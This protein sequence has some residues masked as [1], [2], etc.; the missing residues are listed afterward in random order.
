MHITID[1]LIEKAD[2]ARALAMEKK[3]AAAAISAIKELGVLLGYRAREEDG[4][5]V[6]NMSDDELADIAR[7]GG[8]RTIRP[9]RRAKRSS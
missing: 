3:Q 4:K 9:A 5:A 2:E 7:G 8:K 1:Y 6:E